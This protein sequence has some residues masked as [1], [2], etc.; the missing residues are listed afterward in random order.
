MISDMG[1]VQVLR[2][3]A[4]AIQ[5]FHLARNIYSNESVD[6]EE[7]KGVEEELGDEYKEDEERDLQAL[8]KAVRI[9][10]ERVRKVCLE[11]EKERLAAASTANET[12]AMIMRLQSEVSSIQMQANQ[13]Q[14]MAEQK[15]LHDQEVIHSMR[16]IVLKQESE[17]DILE[18]Q[19]NSCKQGRM[20]DW[21]AGDEDGL[22][23][24]DCTPNRFIEIWRRR[25]D[26]K[27]VDVDGSDVWGLE[28]TGNFYFHF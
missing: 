6:N 13:Y 9:Q 17:R 27:R 16:W 22:K 19:L 12:M 21:K 2:F 20:I 28:I 11:L 15:Q 18:S 24:I 26:L 25:K 1:F 3:V 4:Y 10:R 23:G 8:R 7:E 5:R 14:R